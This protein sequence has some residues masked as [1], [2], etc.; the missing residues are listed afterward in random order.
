MP[1]DGQDAHQQ[2]QSQ[3]QKLQAAQ[4]D[5]FV[6]HLEHAST[7]V[8]T[9]PAWKQQILGGST[10]QPRRAQLNLADSTAESGHLAFV[11]LS[12]RAFSRPSALPPGPEAASTRSHLRA[13]RHERGAYTE[14]KTEQG[15][16]R[17][18]PLS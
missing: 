3:A 9:W 12:P 18:P 11:I 15:R 1:R 13:D 5:A 17:A 7:V 10:T 4:R 16:F 14:R 8:Q 2:A 6:K